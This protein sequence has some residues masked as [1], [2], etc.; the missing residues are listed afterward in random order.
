MPGAGILF[1]AIHNGELHFL[2]GREN[3]YCSNGKFTYCDFGGGMDNGENYKQT[4]ARECS[5][6]M[7]GFL[8][9]YHDLLK[10]LKNDTNYPLYIDNGEH[11]RTYRIFI[12]PMPYL[13]YLPILFNQTCDITAQYLQRNIVSTS[14]ILEKDKMKWMSIHDNST[15]LRKFFKQSI[16]KIR[17]CETKIMEYVKMKLPHIQH[18]FDKYTMRTSVNSK[19]RRRTLVKKTKNNFSRNRKT[20]SLIR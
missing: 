5:E 10:L 11:P 6:E 1:T 12:I 19:T 16:G 18:Y 7:R 2:L 14:K 4:A 13:P 3:K 20:N 15:P 9:N 17:K 8:G